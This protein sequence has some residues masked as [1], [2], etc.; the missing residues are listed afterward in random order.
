MIA[1]YL[2]C[3]QVDQSATLKRLYDIVLKSE[4][5]VVVK[6]GMYKCVVMVPMSHSLANLD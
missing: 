4:Y 3:V 6:A 2:N 1:V 5:V